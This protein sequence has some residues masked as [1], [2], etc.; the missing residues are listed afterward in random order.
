[1]K[2]TVPKASGAPVITIGVA[3]GLLEDLQRG[4]AREERDVTVSE[5]FSE[6][7]Y[8]VCEGCL[9]IAAV[10]GSEEEAKGFVEWL[11]ESNPTS[12]FVAVVAEET[13]NL[14]QRL[15]ADEILVSDTVKAMAEAEPRPESESNLFK[16]KSELSSTDWLDGF[17]PAVAVLDKNLCYLYANRSWSGRFETYDVKGKQHNALFADS[18]TRWDQVYAAALLGKRAEGRHKS[19]THSAQETFWEIN[20]CR[21]EDGDVIGLSIVLIDQEAGTDGT[22]GLLGMGMEEST[23]PVSPHCEAP[24]VIVDFAGK[25]R[26]LTKGGRSICALPDLSEAAPYEDVFPSC[27]ERDGDVLRERLARS[28]DKNWTFSSS[29][30]ESHVDA[31][32]RVRRMLWLNSKFTDANS[33]VVG[34]LRFGTELSK[35]G[36]TRAKPSVEVDEETPELDD[37]V[38]R[39]LCNT[40]PEAVLVLNAAGRVVF[41]NEKCQTL[42]GEDIVKTGELSDVLNEGYSGKD[43]VNELPSELFW[44][45]VW[46]LEEKRTFDLVRDDKTMRLEFRPRTLDNGLFVCNI[47]DVGRREERSRQVED[48]AMRFQALFRDS[49]TPL[50]LL[51]ENLTITDANPAF[52]MFLQ[53]P[54]SAVGGAALTRWI[55]PEHIARVDAYLESLASPRPRFEHPHVVF[56]HDTRILGE[57]RLR[58]SRLREQGGHGTKYACFIEKSDVAG[59]KQKWLP[60]IHGRLRRN[61]EIVQTLARL[62]G[63]EHERKLV[64]IR[65]RLAAFYHLHKMLE[66]DGSKEVAPFYQVCEMQNAFLKELLGCGTEIRLPNADLKLH[67]DIAGPLILIYNELL[68]GLLPA[69]PRLLKVLSSMNEE[70]T[71]ERLEISWRE[72]K[73][74]PRPAVLELAEHLSKEINAD[75]SRSDQSIA[76]CFALDSA[77]N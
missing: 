1:M 70:E 11:R 75:L 49:D 41:A 31:R 12:K 29:D 2:S 30:V 28:A 39:D 71:L 77:K 23:L 5:N 76:V 9:V 22:T 65:S 3:K 24:A 16:S 33:E 8:A 32:G 47:T 67:T 36:L 21:G 40:S 61:L 52:C 46:R 19:I 54:R 4:F 59:E 17:G 18:D 27:G 63:P 15:D 44:A 7:R 35:E 57:G 13:E 48:Q 20:P 58:F 25:V 60:V 50:V 37:G 14:R 26:L 74:T 69:K 38:F 53:M 45:E 43:A 51:N 72:P 64:G 6:A 10:D 68:V 62:S 56:M 73:I 42:L 55:S 34:L 66:L